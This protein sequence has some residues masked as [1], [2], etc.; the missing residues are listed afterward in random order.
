[1]TEDNVIDENYSKCEI[2]NK[3]RID[4]SKQSSCGD[5]CVSTYYSTR[6]VII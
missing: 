5:N 6:M 1:M 3:T 4:S 2:Q